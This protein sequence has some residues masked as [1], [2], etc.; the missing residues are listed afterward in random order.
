M[1]DDLRRQIRRKLAL[2]NPAATHAKSMAACKRLME[3]PEF[4]RAEIIMLYLPMAEE[5]DT[6]PLA[7]RAWQQA[8]T[9][10]APRCDWER[11]KMAPIEIRSMETGLHIARGDVR[12]PA[13]GPAV[14]PP[15][16]DLVVVPA[17]AYDCRGN[18]LGR[19]GGFY[20]RFLASPDLRSV[21]VG[22]AFR[23]Q[24]VDQIP[25]TA[26]DVPV[27]MLVTDEEVLRF[28]APPAAPGRAAGSHQ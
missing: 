26:S 27:R 12:E 25:L 8:K 24:V 15:D 18:R 14:A 1:K 6:T 23:E 17:L 22:L 10:T 9:V 4:E 2:L 11:R 13:E 28:S 3:Q 19:G 16:L 21:T 5:V 7:L 20:D